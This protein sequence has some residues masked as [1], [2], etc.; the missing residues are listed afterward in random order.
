MINVAILSP[1][2][3]PKNDLEMPI[4]YKY[5]SIPDDSVFVPSISFLTK[6]HFTYY[7]DNR[8]CGDSK[9]KYSEVVGSTH[10]ELQIRFEWGIYL[11]ISCGGVAI[12]DMPISN[13]EGIHNEIRDI[14]HYLYSKLSGVHGVRSTDEYKGLEPLCSYIRAPEMPICSSKECSLPVDYFQHS[15]CID[16]KRA[17][18]CRKKEMNDEF[19]L[20]L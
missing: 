9:D 14:P 17:I 20:D 8:K 11:N 2:I 3:M 16:C 4:G 19:N 12:F 7:V 1:R 5:F 6:Y 10:H 18:R 15:H 13:P